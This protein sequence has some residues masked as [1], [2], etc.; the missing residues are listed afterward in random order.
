VEPTQIVSKS[1]TETYD[2]FSTWEEETLNDG[3][4]PGSQK[5]GLSIDVI[6]H[7]REVEYESS[8]T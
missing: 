7:R 2:A 1:Y 8:Q 4:L 5:R 6:T 3:S